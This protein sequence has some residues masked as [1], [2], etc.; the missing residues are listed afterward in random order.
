MTANGDKHH[1]RPPVVS[2][3]TRAVLF[4]ARLRTVGKKKPQERTQAERMADPT[5]EW[6]VMHCLDAW[7]DANGNP[8]QHKVPLKGYDRP[9]SYAE[10]WAALE[11]IEAE[12]PN[13]DFSIRRVAKVLPLRR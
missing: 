2:A 12:R 3:L 7:H 5:R 13:E 4:S 11:K 8:G 9:M 6:I 10:A 1:T